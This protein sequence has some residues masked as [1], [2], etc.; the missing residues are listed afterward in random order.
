MPSILVRAGKNTE[1]MFLKMSNF[2]AAAIGAAL[3][4]AAIVVS[5]GCSTTSAKANGVP[6]FDT[7][8]QA[9]LLDTGLVYYGK[10]SGLDTDYPTLRDVYYIQQTTDSETKKVNNVL[11]RRGNEWH[12]PSLTVLNS[13]HIVL[14]EPVGPTSKVAQLIAAEQNKK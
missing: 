10:I 6:T 4:L 2:R 5:T 7:Q 11:I 12:G 9:V 3:V 1:R 13:K 14:V 8:Y